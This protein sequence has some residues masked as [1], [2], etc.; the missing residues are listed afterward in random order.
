MLNR[1]YCVRIFKLQDFQ[2]NFYKIQVPAPRPEE[3]ESDPMVIPEG[4][5]NRIL[6]ALT[7]PIHA[8]CKATTPDCRK[9][10]HK[11]K[12]TITFLMS[13][14]WISF[15]SYIMVWMITVIGT[16]I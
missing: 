6:W 1:K 14:V 11:E 7:L 5:M 4:T 13:M 10:K 12:Y 9:E 2:T 8:A 15:Y 16:K 3:I